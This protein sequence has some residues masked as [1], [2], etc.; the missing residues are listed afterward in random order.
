[1]LQQGEHTL[2]ELGQSGWTLAA[3]QVTAKLSLK[4]LDCPRQR[5]LGDIALVSSTREIE[6]SRDRE[7]IPN[8]MHFHGRTPMIQLAV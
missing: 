3:E 5:W 2:T 4:L 8:L 1:L 7:E 6:R